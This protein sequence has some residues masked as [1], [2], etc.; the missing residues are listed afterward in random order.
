L[1]I[2]LEVKTVAEKSVRMPHFTGYIARGLALYILNRISPALAQDLHEP[3]AIKPYSVTPLYFRSAKRLHDGYMLDPSSPC[4]F[5]IRFLDDS[6]AKAAMEYFSTNEGMMIYDT[7]FKV[8]S[9]TVRSED[10]TKVENAEAFRMVFDSPAHLAKIGSKYDQLF[11]EPTAIFPNLMRMWDHFMPEEK[12]FGKEVHEKYRQWLA[13]HMAVSGY[14]LR[15]VVVKGKS[16][17]IGFVGWSAYRVDDNGTGFGL[18]TSKL[19]RFAEYSNVGMER[20]AGFGVVKY[21]R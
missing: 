12:R 15:T 8:A 6:L 11:P 17:K 19:A 18:V 5:K 14:D 10:F 1:A 3:N 21:Y 9:L 13:E 7:V 4:S 20:T 16:M 2:E